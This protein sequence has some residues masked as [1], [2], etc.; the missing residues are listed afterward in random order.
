M[1]DKKFRYNDLYKKY[2]MEGDIHIGTGIVRVHDIFNKTPEFM[3]S[4]DFLISDP[5]YNKSALSSFYTKAEIDKKPDSFEAFFYRYFEVLDEINP[6]VVCLE[7]GVPQLEMYMVELKKRYSNI[8]VKKSYYYKN[9]RNKCL[10]VFA[11]NEALP[12]CILNLPELDEETV[13]DIL[14]RDVDFDCVADICMG[15]GLVAFYANKY[16]KKFVGTELNKY[17]LAV[18]CE[19]VTT[20][21]RGSIN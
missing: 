15:L 1:A 8:E 17:R 18:C 10:F 11:S 13:I 21:Q 9:K 4:A 19:R 2:N 20:G 16:G 12:S 5:P 6:R 3:L 7:I 14:C